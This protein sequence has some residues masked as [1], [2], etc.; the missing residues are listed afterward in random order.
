MSSSAHAH[1]EKQD[2]FFPDLGFGLGLR[3]D[4]YPHIFN[5]WPDVDWFEIISENF[6][7]T[8]GRPMRNLA[9]IRERYPVVMHGVSMSIGTVDPIN[10]EYMAKLKKLMDWLKPAWV[11]D[12]LCWTGIAHKNTHDLLPVPYTEEALKQIVSRIKQVQ[13]Y[14]ERPIALENPSTYLEFKAS[15]IREE[16]FISRMA[17][18]SGCHLLLD[19]N[20]VYV[21]CYNHRLDPKAYID[22]MPLDK[23]AQIHLA[24]HTNKG[25]HIVDTH[26]DHVVDEVWA[27]YRY[28]INKAKRTVSTMIEWDGNIPEFNV[29]NAELAKAKV[30]AKDAHNYGT[31]PDLSKNHPYYIANVV[32]PLKEQQT[33]MQSAILTGADAEQ[34]P[35]GWI[36][37]KPDFP[38]AAQLNVYI[39][40]YRWRLYDVVAGDYPVLQAYLG[41]DVFQK[42]IWAFVDAVQS[43]HF[44]I[45]RYAARLPAFLKEQNLDDAFALELATLEKAVSELTDPQETQALEPHH[46][47]GLTPDALMDMKLYPRAALA[48]FVFEAP[49]N[50]Y[51][52]AVKDGMSPE[53][54]APEKSFL[55]VFRHEDVVWRMALGE[56]E[57]YLLQKLFAGVPIGLAMEEL[58]NERA[59]PDDA[60]GA[61]LSEWFSRWMRNGLLSKDLTLQQPEESYAA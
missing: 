7:D 19:V 59:L 47:D 36:R 25:T 42:W 22:A 50:A 31:L 10:S 9:R 8:D 11:S 57:Y 30:A 15:H 14:L 13:D 20:N 55:A 2:S 58:Q 24:G 48:L 41:D 43:D 49:V 53:R 33:R 46:L 40:S 61:H 60:L 45:G 38:A 16:E 3:I 44:N 27:L 51:Y 28:T 54:P 26:D 12:H 34:D 1:F 32:T 4:H 29:L 6:M 5:N 37:D 52:I 18:E 23:V 39:E 56:N 17:E 21:S 35:G